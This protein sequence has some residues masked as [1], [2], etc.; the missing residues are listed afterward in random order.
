M[1]L[2][3][4]LVDYSSPQHSQDLIY[5]LDSYAV[6]P[7]GG[8]KGLNPEVK[9]NLVDE[10]AKLPYAFS[11]LA[12]YKD[13]AVG[14]VN[15][16]EGF[17]TFACKPLINIHDIVVLESFRGRGISQALLAKVEEIAKE[18]GCC[19]ITLEV[20]ENNLA[21]KS[22]YKKFGFAG[23]E[24]DP[25]AGKALFWQKILEDKK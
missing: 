22:A 13:Q 20:L 24:L 11:I 7:M 8:G 9:H 3:I 18:K 2:E 4:N 25:N 5:L 16:L 19:K 21:A 14:L 12:Y 6:D 23:Y 10:L 1:E 15:C 17:S